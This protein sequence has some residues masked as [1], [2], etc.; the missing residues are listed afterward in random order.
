MPMP[1]KGYLLHA[2]LL[3]RHTGPE[4]Q[5]I[6]VQDLLELLQRIPLRARHYVQMAGPNDIPVDVTGIQFAQ[7]DQAEKWDFKVYLVGEGL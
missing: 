3:G 1:R 6:T 2:E 5:G 4:S 7:S